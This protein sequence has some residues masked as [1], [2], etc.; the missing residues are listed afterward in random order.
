MLGIAVNIKMS[1][2]LMVPGFMLVVAFERGLIRALLTLVVIGFVQIFIGIEFLMVN[3]K[4][5]L[6]MSYNFER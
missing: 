4:A 2:L 3:P 5:Y 1:A 6:N